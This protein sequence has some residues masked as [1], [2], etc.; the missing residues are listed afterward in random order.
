MDAPD[1]AAIAA[2]IGDRAR[3][4][5]LMSLMT[6]RAHTASELAGA[7][8]VSRATA[9]AHLSRLVRAGLLTVERTG[10]HGYF[11][12]AGPEVG[13]TVERLAALAAR[14]G[15]SR[16][17][18]GP[19][20]PAMRKARVCYDHLAGD[21]G[22]LVFERMGRLGHI[23]ARDAVL[24]LTESGATFARR[25]G[26]DPDA[27]R[28]GRRPVC[29]AC[30]DWS[31]RRHHLAGALGAA[32]L[33]RFVTLGWARIAAKGRVVHFSAIGERALLAALR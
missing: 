24:E 27:L 17:D 8:G 4:T 2:L 18:T 10:R 9:S 12:L 29:R 15:A 3:A 5:M 6:G 19:A 26:V 7:A 20:D 25:V 22:V 16:I 23:R 14:V 11:R 30:L 33:R 31:V 28:L 13:E 21:L 32:L 1:I